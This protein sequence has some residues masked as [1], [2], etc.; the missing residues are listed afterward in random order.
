MLLMASAS[1]HAADPT[2]HPLLQSSDIIPIGSF[3]LPSTFAYGGQSLA[4]SADGNKLYIS[5]HN[6]QQNLGIINIPP[7]LTGT[8]T[9]YQAPTYV[10][11]HVVSANSARLG[12]SLVYN[13]RLIIA[14]RVMYDGGTPPQQYSYTAGDLNIS[15]FSPISAFGNVWYQTWVSGYM[16]VIPADWQSLLG[17]PAFTGNSSMSIISRGSNGP[18]FFV[19]DPD[20]V[21]VNSP[22]PSIPLMYYYYLNDSDYQP[23]ANPYAP[24]DIWTRADQNNAGTIF[25]A[26]TRSIL[27]FSKHGYGQPTYK[28]MT[29]DPCDPSGQGEQAYPYRRQITA[30]DANDLLAVKTGTKQPW[31]V[32]PYAWWELPDGSNYTC[33]SFAYSG[34]AYDPDRRRIYVAFNYGEN[35]A[36]EVYGVKALIT[37][38]PTINFTDK[39]VTVSFSDRNMINAE[40]S[41]NYRLSYRFNNTWTPLPISN[42]I[43]S[44]GNG[45][46]FTF[47]ILSELKSHY[48]YQLEVTQ[49]AGAITNAFGIPLTGDSALPFVLND[50][51][52]FHPD[53]STENGSDN[54]GD[55]WQNG[56]VSGDRSADGD[57][58]RDGLTNAQEAG[59]YGTDPELADS[60]GDGMPDA[61]EVTISG[62]DPFSDD[63]GIDMDF[64]GIVNLDEYRWRTDPN[65]GNPAPAPAILVSPAHTETDIT[66]DVKLIT[67]SA[68]Y[69]DPDPHRK[70]R[71]QISKTMNWDT[72]SDLVL[73][74]LTD[75]PKYLYEYPVFAVFM[76]AGGSY[77]WRAAFYDD[78]SG[79]IQWTNVVHFFTMVSRIGTDDPAGIEG[80]PDDQEVDG[81]I[82]LNGD[83]TPDNDPAIADNY[84]AV[85]TVVGSGQIAVERGANTQKIVSLRSLDPTSLD[86]ST[87]GPEMPLGLVSFKIEVADPSLPAYV[88]L[89]A[90]IS[91]PKGWYKYDPK[92]GWLDYSAFATFNGDG[93]VTLELMDGGYGD[94]DGIRNGIIVDPSGSGVPVSGTPISAAAGG[95]GG[96]GGCFIATAAY[97]S[98]LDKHVRILSEFR[99]RFLLPYCWGKKFVGWYYRNSPS[100]AHKLKNHPIALETVRWALLPAVGFSYLSVALHPA[101]AVSV[102]V[103]LLWGVVW[104]VSRGWANLRRRKFKKSPTIRALPKQAL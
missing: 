74:V 51:L 99:D 76:E 22:I 61:Y 40:K 95:G 10:P 31:E 42:G 91:L 58:D 26:G 23:I 50:D 79:G 72:E 85:N 69:S 87:G 24:N 46:N 29:A 11:G 45:Q 18:S 3:S 78:K 80:I 68:S 41:G 13:N 102:C 88:T 17:G 20:D 21:G 34:L 57:Y 55:L 1:G 82:D 77:W 38:K 70:T 60:D 49:A 19:F 98:S 56:L 63:S 30:F 14:K 83:G 12:G 47:S 100:L 90:S 96:G 28:S 2:Q 27:F 9:T 94:S 39:T 81:S 54:V 62:L 89:Y 53:G 86:E 67:D 48:V 65:N 35:P 93:S 75:N 59:Q 15:N 25:P 16:G 6:E 33:E 84:K 104:A 103:V 8:A 66:L 73:D 4:V 97:G 37:Q 32:Q 52:I 5:Q 101:A 7:S 43:D 64:D 92:T 44:S 71:W 36:I